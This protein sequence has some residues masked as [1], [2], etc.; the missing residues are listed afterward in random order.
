M[1]YFFVT[2][3][4]TILTLFVKAQ[5]DVNL[6]FSYYNSKE[7]AKAQ[8]YFKKLYDQQ[9]T[10]FY[11]EYYI[12][13]LVLQQEYKTADKEIEKQTKK[14][15]ENLKLMVLNIYTYTAWGKV[16]EA[17][18]V[19]KNLMQKLPS[20]E[21]TI[22]DIANQLISIGEFN[23]AEEVYKKGETIAPTKFL[24]DLAR[25][26][27]IKR[28]NQAIINAYLDLALTD[29]QKY[30]QIKVIFSKKMHDDVNEEFAMLLEKT[31]VFR[32]QKTRNIAYDDFLVWFYIEKNRLDEALTY[33]NSLDKR[34]N[35]PSRAYN[36]GIKA[37]ENKDY[38]LASKAFLIVKEYGQMSPY[39]NNAQAYLLQSFY[40]Q[41][42][43][44]HISDSASINKIEKE[45]LQYLNSGNTN[46]EV[47]SNFVNLEAFY[48]NNQTIAL[49]YINKTLSQPITQE[50]K[51]KLIKLKGDIELF[52]GRI[53][54]A[55]LSYANV[56]TNYVYFQIADDAK[57]DKAKAYYFLHQFKW[58][59]DQFDILKGSPS[60]L[61]ANDAIF[62][63][64]FIDYNTSWDSDYTALE[65][66]ANAEYKLFQKKYKDALDNIDTILKKFSTD[67]L[68]AYA[69]FL[70]SQIYIEQENYEKAKQILE[71][72]TKNYAT[73]PIADKAL[74]NL[75]IIYEVKLKDKSKA[76]EIYKLIFMNY[77]SSLYSNESKKKYLEL[78][79][80]Q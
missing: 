27:E 9:K 62:M 37:F 1:K 13:C 76:Q 49:E 2:L 46:F 41:I 32:I 4:I 44:K 73:D 17:E 51:A 78:T 52:M 45:Y 6:A 80:I 39:Y 20:N 63:S 11:F 3:I 70:K 14:T 33:G 79:N 22:R 19:F 12:R 21:L 8:D 69:L 67:A 40:N 38:I 61:I 57:F 64:Y 65:Y 34:F 25:L 74:F 55:I 18:Q 36:I 77:S 31:L 29:N 72:F 10:F 58:A 59:K 35:S 26:Y 5:D 24:E 42:V 71:L 56:E 15:P 54:D 75:A 66:Y 50:N 47:L 60:K 68:V 28:D 30:D 7:Y 23:K 53:W 43:E 16:Q 48:L